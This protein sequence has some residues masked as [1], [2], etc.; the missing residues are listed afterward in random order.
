MHVIVLNRT[1]T[2]AAFFNIRVASAILSC[3]G[4]ISF[5]CMRYFPDRWTTVTV[6]LVPYSPENKSPLLL[7]PPVLAEVFSLVI[8]PPSSFTALEYSD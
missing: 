8:K 5:I 4:Q 2:A 7:D 3:S 1:C 6:R